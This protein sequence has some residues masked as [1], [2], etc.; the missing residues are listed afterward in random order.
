[1]A[2]KKEKKKFT[3]KQLKCIQLLA[4]KEY[5]NFSFDQ[6]AKMV[7][8]SKTSIFKWLEDIDFKN[9]VAKVSMSLITD[10]APTILKTTADLLQSKD[11]RVR[12]KGID[13][14]LK[15]TEKMEQMQKVGLEEV[16]EIDFEEKSETGKAIE[17]FIEENPEAAAAL[18]RNWLNEDWD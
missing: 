18:L 9:E 15:A 14:F 8:C 17:K 13:V 1:M 7:P 5:E 6:I 11:D 16:E 10:L 4:R 2:V 12:S 3:E